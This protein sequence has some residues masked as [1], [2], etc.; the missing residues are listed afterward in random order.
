M[1]ETGQR[2]HPPP[3]RIS[4]LIA[5][6]ASSH[7]TSSITDLWR[8]AEEVRCRTCTSLSCG[9]TG[10]AFSPISS[11]TGFLLDIGGGGKDVGGKGVRLRTGHGQREGRVKE[12]RISLRIMRAGRSRCSRRTGAEPDADGVTY[13]AKGSRRGRQVVRALGRS[14]VLTGREPECNV[15]GEKGGFRDWPWL[16]NRQQ[17]MAMGEKRWVLLMWYLLF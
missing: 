14:P 10:G 2:N 1:W 9:D 15:S 17:W 5:P 4:V 12:R 7:C 13:A 6:Q 3:I 11:W 8:C 16:R